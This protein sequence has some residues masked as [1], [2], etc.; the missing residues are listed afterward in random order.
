ML[1][2]SWTQLTQSRKKWKKRNPR[3]L[4]PVLRYATKMYDDVIDAQTYGILIPQKNSIENSVNIAILRMSSNRK[5][6]E[7]NNKWFGN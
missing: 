2:L 7:I 3:S 1:A 4:K 5:L 6:D